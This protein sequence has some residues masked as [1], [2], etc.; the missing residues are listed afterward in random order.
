MNCPKCSREYE[1]GHGG[2]LPNHATPKGLPSN[3]EDRIAIDSCFCVECGA[4][5][6]L[7][8]G[9]IYS[10]ARGT[11]EGWK[12]FSQPKPNPKKIG[13]FTVIQK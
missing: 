11:A 12:I 3:P 8:N 6:Q 2:Y 10:W 13:G 1:L 5:I 7:Q 9:A 4:S